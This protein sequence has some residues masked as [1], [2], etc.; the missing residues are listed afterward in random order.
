[1]VNFSVG[2]SRFQNF[3]TAQ[4]LEAADLPKAFVLHELLGI[5][6]L[7]IT[8]SFCYYFPL[9]KIP[10]FETQLKKLP[11]MQSFSKS[12]TMSSVIDALSSKRGVAYLE[13]SC[14]R[15]L[16]RPFTI[17]GKMWVVFLILKAAK[18]AEV[19]EELV[20]VPSKGKAVVKSIGRFEH[21]IFSS[22]SS[23]IV[24]GEKLNLF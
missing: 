18:G 7:A 1:M 15:K 5:T 14:L 19:E 16:I 2:F 23:S 21:S 9:S 20:V 24:R 10:F 8:W 13:S 11:P 4:G 3:L 12:K 6:M 22:R 17:P